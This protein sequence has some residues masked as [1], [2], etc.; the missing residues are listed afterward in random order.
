MDPEQPET[1]NQSPEE[2]SD[3]GRGLGTT[4]LP[5]A[6]DVVAMRALRETR[7]RGLPAVEEYRVV[8]DR[9]YR[10][11]FRDLP[12]GMLVRWIEETAGLFYEDFLALRAL[13][14]RVNAALA[15]DD[16]PAATWELVC[17][18]SSD[19]RTRLV[20]GIR[21]LNDLDDAGI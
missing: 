8:S 12:S 15:A 21:R 7:L 11:G 17:R 10:A 16:I 3:R 19:A 2:Y 6:A 13:G 18:M 1:A 9:L 5:P 20:D 4:S 14:D